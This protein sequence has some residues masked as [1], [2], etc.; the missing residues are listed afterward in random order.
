MIRLA[1]DHEAGVLN[2]V[3]ITAGNT[4]KVRVLPVF[5]VVSRI[6]PA[7]ND[8]AFTARSVI[9]KQIRDGGAVGH[10]IGADSL[11]RDSVLA[12]GPG[13]VRVAGNRGVAHSAGEHLA[14]DLGPSFRERSKC[15]EGERRASPEHGELS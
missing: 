6:V 15:R 1:I 10:E 3:R 7:A 12:V 8:I 5:G 14:G 2:A 11:A 9:D 13:Q 4:A